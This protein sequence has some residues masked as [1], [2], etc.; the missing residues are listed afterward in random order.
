MPAWCTP[1]ARETGVADV[2]LRDQR[3]RRR[4]VERLADPHQRPRDHEFVERRHMPGPPGDQ[5]PDEKTAADD[6]APAEAVGDVSTKW[7]Q[8]R[9]RPLEATQHQTPVGP[10]RNGRNVAD[11]R[12]LHRGEHLPVEIVE[13]RDRHQQRDDEPGVAQRGWRRGIFHGV[14]FSWERGRPR[15]L[16][17]SRRPGT[18]ALPEF[19]PRHRAPVHTWRTGR[20]VRGRSSRRARATRRRQSSSARPVGSRALRDRQRH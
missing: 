4:N 10:V 2:V 20:K 5:R 3:Q 6:P 7:T 19:T 18:A 13:H 16:S 8:D 11:H 1:T 9:V 12:G 15:P 17:Q 14:G